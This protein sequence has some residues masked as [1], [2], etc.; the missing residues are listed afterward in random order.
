MTMKTSALGWSRVLI[1]A[2]QGVA[3]YVLF[4]LLPKQNAMIGGMLLTTPLH[5][6]LICLPLLANTGLGYLRPRALL[7]WLG[8]AALVLGALAV[9]AVWRTAG[10]ESAALRGPGAPGE[11]WGFLTAAGMFMAHVLVLAAAHDGQRIASYATYFDLAWKL[12]I[13][14][15]FSGAFLGSL[16]LVLW[17]GATLFNLLGLKWLQHLLLQ[18]WF[19]IPFSAMAVAWALHLTD[20]KPDIVRG[21]RALFLVLL[22]W[23]LPVITLVSAIFLVSLLWTGLEPLWATRRASVVLLIAAATIILLINAA[24]QSGDKELKISRVVRWS[25]YLGAVLLMPLVILA[26]H[27]LALR[28]EQYGWSADRIIAAAAL[29]VAVWYA[30][31][32]GAATLKRHEGWLP[33]VAR[34]NIGATW[35]ILAVL[36]A[37]LSPVADPARLA[38]S[39]QVSRLRTGQ[40]APETFD[41]AYL[42][43]GAGRWGRD[44]LDAMIEQRA[45]MPETIASIVA[46]NAKQERSPLTE[47]ESSPAGHDAAVKPVHR[48]IAAVWPESRMLPEGFLEQLGRADVERVYDW[49]W[50]E[51]L[52]EP[53]VSC[54]AVLLQLDSDPGEEVLLLQ[55]R[56]NPTAV[57]FDRD[58]QEQWQLVAVLPDE[59]LSCEAVRE[60]LR[61]GQFQYE[62]ARYQNLRLG[63]WSVHVLPEEGRRVRPRTTDQDGCQRAVSP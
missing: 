8:A 12:A 57:I 41:Y 34:V 48:P 17:L 56:P 2:V 52:S 58:H 62:P 29:A 28:V 39:D 20:V 11:V 59:L 54:E 3:L 36:L 47:S 24:Y 31:G 4:D 6:L 44:M 33:L 7:Q 46:Q 45:G 55:D 14:C 61:Q 26:I 53:G 40:I 37:L 60:R 18:G 19:A 21:I 43:S 5:A 25:G 30:T 10:T 15:V 38:V 49:V 32:Y 16:W 22:S 35:L 23:L 9:Y 42:T 27:A 13:Q 50:P 63:G 51:C 1:G